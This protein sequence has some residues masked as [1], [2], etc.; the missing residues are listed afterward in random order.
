MKT[1]TIIMNSRGYLCKMLWQSFAVL[2]LSFLLPSVAKADDMVLQVWQAD[3]KVM[4]INL[5]EQPVTTY[6]DGQLIIKTTKTT[7]TFP[8][9]QVVKYT[10]TDATGISTPSAM[11]SQFSADGE[12]ITFTGL[13]PNTPVYLYTVAGQLL[14]TVT[15]TGQSKTVVSV[16]R[17]P[18]GVYVVKANGVTF[19]ITKQ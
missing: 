18:V 16:S 2:F 8:L 11:G 1:K 13:K 3:G 12:S 14:K 6:S 15:A 5:N 19:K 7:F 4:S 17:F 10:Y 9:E